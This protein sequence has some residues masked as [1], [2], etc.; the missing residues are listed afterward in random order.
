MSAVIRLTDNAAN[1]SLDALRDAIDDGGAAGHMDI[2]A[3]T[4][5]LTAETAIGSQTKLGTVTFSYPSAPNASSRTL[6]FDTITG[7]SS[8]DASGTAAWARIYTSAGTEVMDVSIGSGSGVVIQFNTTV[9][10]SGGPIDVTAFTIA[11]ASP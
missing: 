4:I 8:A 9:I 1:L 5:P 7:D 6:T 11:V 3:G 10:V 2:Y